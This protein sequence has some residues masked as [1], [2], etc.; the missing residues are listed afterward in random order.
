MSD[1]LIPKPPPVSHEIQA[2]RRKVENRIA[3][4][5]S[6]SGKKI[7]D[8]MELYV[9]RAFD[10]YAREIHSLSVKLSYADARVSTLQ[11]E[12]DEQV[13]IVAELR[14]QLAAAQG[15]QLIETLPIAYQR[16]GAQFLAYQESEV[17]VA[18][19]TDEPIPRLVFRK[20]GLATYSRHRRIDAEMDGQPVK[21]LVEI[22]LPW[23]EEYCHDWVCWTR[24]FE[25]NPTHW[26]PLVDLP[27]SPSET[28]RVG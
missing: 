27:L 18:R 17:Y 26:M 12:K 9:L 1:A 13:A 2:A 14:A 10:A 25:F 20:H 19:Y 21:A 15:W 28:G 7:A 23:R 24:G 22:D 16:N 3:A 4:L 5:R 11:R 6:H 8:E